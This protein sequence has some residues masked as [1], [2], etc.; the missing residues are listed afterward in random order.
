MRRKHETRK[1]ETMSPTEADYEKLA[2]TLC[3]AR[4]DDPEAPKTI[5]GGETIPAWQMEAID[6]DSE[7]VTTTPETLDDFRRNSRDWR[8]P[9][10]CQEIAGGLYWDRCQATKGQPRCELCIVDCGEFRLV[11]QC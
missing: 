8:E 3:E 4:G 2:R 6:Q 5:L 7:L 1:D 10:R 9:G 11:F